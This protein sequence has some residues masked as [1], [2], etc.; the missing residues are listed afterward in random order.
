[1]IDPARIEALL[2]DFG[3]VL[4]EIDFGRVCAR[5]A[6]LA[7]RPVEH[8]HARFTHGEAYER[9]ERGEM[10]I[11]AYCETLRRDLGLELADEQLLDG[12]QRV[13]V[14]E[15]GATVDLVKRLRGRMPL[16]VFTNTNVAHYTHLRRRFAG[17][18]AP[19]DR[20]FASHE[21]RSRKPQAAAFRQI[22][23]E[24]GV[25]LERMLFFDDTAANVEAARALGM[26]A[27]LVRGPADVRDALHPWIDV[28]PGR[29]GT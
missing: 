11:A 19:F 22:E 18:L 27:V 13:F 26:P 17:A 5:W 1:M 25:A 2:F 28:A 4:V 14:G 10:D 21:M 12:W 6:E 20:I 29:T 7:G 23:R 16:Y 24:T 9:H 8:V 3:G 15:I